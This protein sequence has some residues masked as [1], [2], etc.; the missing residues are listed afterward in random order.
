MD[1]VIYFRA[2]FF[3]LQPPRYVTPESL[4][5]MVESG[6]LSMELVDDSVRRILRALDNV[7]VFTEGGRKASVRKCYEIHSYL[8]LSVIDDVVSD[9]YPYHHEENSA[10]SCLL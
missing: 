10:L 2:S 4:K 1:F 6:K 9:E 3:I 8:T 7:G 5:G